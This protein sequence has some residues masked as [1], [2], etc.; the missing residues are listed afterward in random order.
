MI[1]EVA[2]ILEDDGIGYW[3]CIGDWWLG[4]N[5]SVGDD[6]ALCVFLLMV[7]ACGNRDREIFQCLPDIMCMA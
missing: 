3:G 1:L 5:G 2:M 7:L 4:E 6:I